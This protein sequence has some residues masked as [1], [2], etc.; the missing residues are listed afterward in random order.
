MDVLRVDGWRP[1][2]FKQKAFEALA[3]SCHPEHD[4]VSD[5]TMVHGTRTD[6]QVAAAAAAAATFF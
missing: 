5:H 2:V 1:A 3:K 6:L 4:F